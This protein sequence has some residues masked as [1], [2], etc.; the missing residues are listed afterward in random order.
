MFGQLLLFFAMLYFE[1]TDNPH[2]LLTWL[3]SLLI[4]ACILSYSQ[5]HTLYR[6]RKKLLK[7]IGKHSLAE[8]IYR[9]T[10]VQAPT[11]TPSH[12]PTATWTRAHARTHTRTRARTRA[13]THARTHTH[14]DT[15]T[16]RHTRT[17]IQ[18]PT[19][20]YIRALSY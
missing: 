3:T 10:H 1:N 13:R 12:T 4:K 17:H 14:I 20:T 19:H 7:C 16:R 9:V 18:A 6:V 8:N 2:L 11:H 5:H 15:H